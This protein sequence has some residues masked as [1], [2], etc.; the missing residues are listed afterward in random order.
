MHTYAYLHTYTHLHTYKPIYPHTHTPAHTHPQTHTL[1]NPH[2]STHLHSPAHPH[3]PT[4]SPTHPPH[5]QPPSHTQIDILVNN[6]GRSQR[7]YFV[8][9]DLEVHR[10]MM[11]LNVLAPMSLT[12]HVSTPSTPCV[13]IALINSRSLY[14]YR[15]K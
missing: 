4:P 7:G 8:N 5:K 14:N 6:A 15:G 1:T 3:S 2:T 12:K 11:E 10:Q 9:T 13:I